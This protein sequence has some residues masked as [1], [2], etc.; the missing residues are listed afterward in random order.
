[1]PKKKTALEKARS[2]LKKAE[3]PHAVSTIMKKLK[4]KPKKIVR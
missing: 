3:T 2:M 1:M 4:G